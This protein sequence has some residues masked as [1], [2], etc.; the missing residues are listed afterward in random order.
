[1]KPSEFYEKYW[2]IK[3][4]DGS[5]VS[6]RKLSDKEKEY[7]DEVISDINPDI[8]GIWFSRKRGAPVQIDAEL[9]KQEMDKLPAFLKMTES[10]RL[11]EQRRIGMFIPHQQTDIYGNPYHNEKTITSH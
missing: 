2:K 4:P 11:K 6:P 1:M 7:M 10:E 9:L 8:K 3:K 5:I